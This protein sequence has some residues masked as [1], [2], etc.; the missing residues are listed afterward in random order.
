MHKAKKAARTRAKNARFRADKAEARAAA[1]VDHDATDAKR[2]KL[3]RE[4]EP[5]VCDLARAAELAMTVHDNEGLF[6]FAV[7]Q[8]NNMAQRFRAS[9]YAEN[10][11]PI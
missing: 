10:F 3:Y 7:D 4:M 5:Y 9:Y 8:F 11:P 2:A 1:V 6:L